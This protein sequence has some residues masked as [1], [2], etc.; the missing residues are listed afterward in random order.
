MSF[1]F[2]WSGLSRQSGTSCCKCTRTLPSCRDGCTDNISGTTVKFTIA[3][4]GTPSP[5][6]I[7]CACDGF[8][9]TPS[10][11]QFNDTY[12]LIIASGNT[13]DCTWHLQ[14][15]KTS[16]SLNFSLDAGFTISGGNIQWFASV[17]EYD[18][19]G[20]IIVQRKGFSTPTTF[21]GGCFPTSVSMT[22]Y[23][24]IAWFC[25]GGDFSLSYP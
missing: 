20:A 24:E 14:K 25:S 3:N 23:T 13:V 15:V 18:G 1:N 10:D 22:S 19:T 2:R 7:P 6:I 5:P 9:V 21:S 16:C 4:C 12:S 17:T 8:L 11:L